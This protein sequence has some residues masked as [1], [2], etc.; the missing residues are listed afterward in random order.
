[1]TLLTIV[2]LMGSLQFLCLA[3]IGD[4]VGRVLE[5]VKSRPHF[6]VESVLND[7]RRARARRPPCRRAS[8]AL[9][10]PVG[11]EGRPS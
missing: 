8:A 9:P 10:P 11:A 5:E 6:L 3:V 4:Y 1:M 7:P 2:L